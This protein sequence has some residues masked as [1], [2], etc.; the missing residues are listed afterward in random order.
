MI[1]EY[2]GYD[3][4]LDAVRCHCRGDHPGSAAQAMIRAVRVLQQTRS[5]AEIIA[6]A[7]DATAW[8]EAIRLYV[9]AGPIGGNDAVLSRKILPLLFLAID[10]ENIEVQAPAP[11]PKGKHF[12]AKLAARMSA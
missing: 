3:A 4:V 11:I 2:T 12:T 8:N 5:E 7:D 6:L 1:D 9:R 10:E